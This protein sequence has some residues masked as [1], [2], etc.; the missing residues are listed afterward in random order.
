MKNK[1]R[2]II[3]TVALLFIVA[4][5]FTA[6]RFYSAPSVTANTSDM[7]QLRSLK[8]IETMK[9]PGKVQ[10]AVEISKGSNEATDVADFIETYRWGRAHFNPIKCGDPYPPSMCQIGEVHIYVLIQKSGIHS[11]T[12][13][14]VGYIVTASMWLDQTQIDV[15]LDKKGNALPATFQ[16]LVQFHQ[17]VAQSSQGSSGGLT[18]YDNPPVFPGFS[19]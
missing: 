5:G 12:G 14:V 13:P 3:N 10:V 6:T 18:S 2:L 4:V 11:T 16:A 8:V 19:R 1:K 7:P 17:D 9:D 15:L